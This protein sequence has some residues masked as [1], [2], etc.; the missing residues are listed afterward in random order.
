MV[1]LLFKLFE[2]PLALALAAIACGLMTYGTYC[3]GPSQFAH[4]HNPLFSW[5]SW[6]AMGALEV[7]AFAL[8]SI[9]MLSHKRSQ[10]RMQFA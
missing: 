7:I 6:L 5:Y 2:S 8:V 4:A 3:D 1:T 10:R 9:A